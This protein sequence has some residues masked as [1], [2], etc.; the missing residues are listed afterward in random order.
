MCSGLGFGPGTLF[1]QDLEQETELC[2]Y[3]KG[4][5]LIVG[6]IF[7]QL[8]IVSVHSAVNKYPWKENTVY[9]S[10]VGGRVFY[11]AHLFRPPSSVHEVLNKYWPT[12]DLSSK[13][14]RASQWAAGKGHTAP[15]NCL[16]TEDEG[17]HSVD[18][19]TLW[20]LKKWEGGQACQ[21]R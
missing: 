16:L 14:C 19:C 20:S 13:A 5:W 15:A 4:G 1:V 9:I 6:K 7:T 17:C 2:I 12:A 3:Q 21:V 10:I 11:L 8:S 18:P